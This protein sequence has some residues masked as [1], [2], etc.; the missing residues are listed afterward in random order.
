MT[1]TAQP[2]VLNCPKCDE[3]MRRLTAGSAQIDRCE[4]CFGIWL[5]KGERNKL[6]RDKATVAG[7]DIGSAEKGRE[8]D[9]I[10]EVECPR[11]REPMSHI[12]DRAQKHIGFEFC[13]ECQGSF[14]DAGELTD[15]SEFTL[16]ERIRSFLGR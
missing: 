1:E 14:F 6:L 2:D 13:R 15:L 7:V 8:Q 11:C 9:E 16:S 12:T 4:R 10:T 3:P 5:D